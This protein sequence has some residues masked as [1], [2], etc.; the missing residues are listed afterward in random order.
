MLAAAGVAANI[1]VDDL[2]PSDSQKVRGGRKAEVAGE[3]LPLP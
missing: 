3:R 2:S 1:R